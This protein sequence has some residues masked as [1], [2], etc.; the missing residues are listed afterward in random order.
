MSLA[1]DALN[2][3]GLWITRRER[4]NERDDAAIGSVLAAV[5]ATKRYLA[6]RDRG[7]PIDRE[8]EGKLVELWTSAAVHIRRS[9]RDLAARLQ[10]K[11]AYWTNPE[12]WTA[13]EVSD[14]RIQIDDIAEEGKRLLRQI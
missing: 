13:Q 11:A 9:D 6:Q 4:K 8:V 3:V 10:D 14:N 7:D 2:G 5:N 1:S 12:N